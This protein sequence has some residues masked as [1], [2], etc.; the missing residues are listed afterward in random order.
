MRHTKRRTALTAVACASALILAGCTGGDGNGNGD[1]AAEEVPEDEFETAMTTETDLTFWTWVPDIQNQ[2]DMFMEE[3]PAISVEVVNVGQG[4]DHYQKLRSALEAGQGAP[5]VVQLEFQH[6]QSFL[7]G[8]GEL[9]DLSPYL[10]EDLSGQYAEW[11]WS[12]VS[13]GEAVYAIPQDIGPMGN[14]Y[15]ED[16]LTEAGVEPPTTWEEFAEAARTYREAKPDS[17]LTNM[18]GNDAGQFVG[19]LWQAGARPFDFDGAETVTIDLDT[20]EVQQ[21][22]EYWDGLVR[23]D[24]IATDPDFTDEWYQ[25]LANGKYA[26]WQTAAWGPVFLQG[27]A[28]NTSGLW[29]AAPLPQWEGEEESAGNWG[30]STNAVLKGTDNPIPAAELARW[31]NVEREPALRFATEQFLFPASD[32]ILEAEEFLSQESEFY[33]GQQ[34][35]QQFADISATVTPDFGWLPF[36]DYTYSSFNETLGKAFADKTD[37]MAGLQA[38]EQDLEQ[39]ATDQGFTVE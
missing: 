23:E 14:L 22:V 3:Y 19:F 32:E 31:I 21:V 8:E 7:L 26:S 9:M 10:T 33:G 15:R 12:Q 36:M 16:L 11:I 1:G 4:A 24:L 20:P 5:D 28:G 35:N 38:W 18:P 29:R 2:V 34:V 39:Y 27:T 13:D 6:I 37:L 30:G 25:G 17:Y